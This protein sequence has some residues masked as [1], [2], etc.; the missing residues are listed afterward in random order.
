MRR[1]GAVDLAVETK[2]D[3]TP[4]S[5]ADRAVEDAIRASLSEQRADDAVLGEE[6]GATAGAAD[7][8]R[9]WLLD[10]IDG[11]KNFLRGLPVWATFLAL[12]VPDEMVLGIPAAPASARP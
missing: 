4:V 7:T 2:P 12:Q 6:H 10:P 9:R 11:T 1:F 3:L 8:Q 5:D